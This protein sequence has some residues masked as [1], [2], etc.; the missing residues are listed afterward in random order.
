[1]IEIELLPFENLAAI[2]ALIFVAS[3]YVVAR[4]LDFPARQFVEK[5]QQ[6]DPWHPHLDARS[7]HHVHF[8]DRW[9]VFRKIH[10]IHE[11]KDAK[12]IRIVM[13]YRRMPARE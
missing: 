11:R 6:Y 7:V 8:V 10:P 3:E 5:R 12:I 4:E 13:N 2:L 9:I 1:M